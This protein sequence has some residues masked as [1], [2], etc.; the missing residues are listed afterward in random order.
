M[1]FTQRSGV[2]PY[3]AVGITRETPLWH[4]GAPG[5]WV[6]DFIVP[7]R[8][9]WRRGIQYGARLHGHTNGVVYVSPNREFARVFATRTDAF[10]GRGVLYRV[11]AS[12]ASSLTHDPDDDFPVTVSI[13]CA[14]ARVVSIEETRISMSSAESLKVIGPYMTWDDGRPVYDANG[15][16]TPAAN[17]PG[18][19]PQH[20]R[21]LGPWNEVSDV[22]FN[23][24]T[25][26]VA[27]VRR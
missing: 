4:G 11:E 22:V 26:Q 24:L 19:D 17:W 9:C 12:P 1:T 16:M 8:E 15:Y 13:A 18:V 6:G 25:R 20:V 14:R 21:D 10:K 27:L 7:E 2:D 5:I 23:R 3:A